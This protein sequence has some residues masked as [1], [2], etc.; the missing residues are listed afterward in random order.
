L[1]NDSNAFISPSTG[2]CIWD[3]ADTEANVRHFGV[4]AFGDDT[5]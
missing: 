5:S 1:K 3:S 4:Y 2:A